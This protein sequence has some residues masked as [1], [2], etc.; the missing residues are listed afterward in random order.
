MA[1]LDG[2]PAYVDQGVPG[3]VVDLQV[4]RK[5]KNVLQAR[6][7]QF[8]RY[9]EQRVEPFCQHF[10]E[11][12]GCKWQNLPYQ[13]QLHYKQKAVWAAL[14][15]V[16]QP[17]PFEFRDILP[18]PATRYYRNKLE[19]TFS[20]RRWLSQSEVESEQAIA[21]RNALGFHIPGMF[22][23][24][25]DIEQCYLQPEPS[26]AIRQSLRAFALE[27]QLEFYDPKT[28]QGFLRTLMIRTTNTG[29]TMVVVAFYRDDR[30][31]IAQVMTHLVT[32]F[33]EITSLLYTINPKPNDSLYDL[34]MVC[35]YGQ[36][37][38]LETL[39]SLKFQ[40]GAKSFFQ[41]N[42]D[43]ALRLYQVVAQFANLTGQETVY[44]LYTGTGTIANFIAQ[45]AKRVIGVEYIAEAID[46]AQE[47]SRLNGITNTHFVAGDIKDILT[48][49]WVEQQGHP[50]VLI[51]DPPRAGMHPDV[52]NS[53]L[54]TNP[55]RIV[56]VSCNPE[57][58]ANDLR[59]LQSQYQVC[60][61]QPVDMFPQT[62]H[63]ENVVLLQRRTLS[64]EMG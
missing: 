6:V 17:E 16:E 42:T 52:V 25:L 57:T 58:Q 28:H 33:P 8:H 31:Q 1:W 44:D 36:D 2:T 20:S 27:Q 60:L 43:Q 37:F 64:G 24:V 54:Q 12:G 55:A 9:S 62:Y 5:R 34:E 41:T 38:I 61:V 26:N 56:Y 45:Q 7:L 35:W 47:N 23:R 14:A 22:D 4:T 29:E 19:Y 50:D 53:I 63:V 48:P 46:N 3:D 15:K 11:C 49:E 39:G 59:L 18:A 13:E 32:Q 30:Y 10:G 51:T 21:Q 40:I